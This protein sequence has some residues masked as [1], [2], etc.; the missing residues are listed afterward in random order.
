MQHISPALGPHPYG[1][2]MSSSPICPSMNPP[3]HQN[4][5]HVT[6]HIYRRWSRLALIELLLN[7]LTSGSMQLPDDFANAYMKEFSVPP[8]PDVITYCRREL[9]HAVI[10]LILEGK[11]ADTYKN[12][13]LIKFPDGITCCVFPRFYC[14]SANY[15]EKLVGFCKS[16]QI[17][18]SLRAGF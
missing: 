6:S 5:Q 17:L 2:S 10:Q 14:Y 3:G 1:L 16:K 4:S 15:P 12:G 7:P 11:F 18:T 8:P 9:Y 13:I